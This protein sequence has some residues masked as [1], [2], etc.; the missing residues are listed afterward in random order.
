MN[1][2]NLSSGYN[3]VARP[4]HFR[5]PSCCLK[6]NFCVCLLMAHEPEI[7]YYTLK[8]TFLSPMIFEKH[9]KMQP[10]FRKHRSKY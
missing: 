1:E 9:K 5:L 10:Q 2:W 4:L 8:H 7:E 6:L 3:R